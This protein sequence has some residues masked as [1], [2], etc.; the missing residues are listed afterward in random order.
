MGILSTDTG[1][2]GLDCSGVLGLGTRREILPHHHHPRHSFDEPGGKMKP[3]ILA[4]QEYAGLPACRGGWLEHRGQG[5][6]PSGGV[7]Y[8]GLLEGQTWP[9]GVNGRAPRQRTQYY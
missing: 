1:E 9:S 3:T 7:V 8:I 2:I 4:S 6:L 5:R